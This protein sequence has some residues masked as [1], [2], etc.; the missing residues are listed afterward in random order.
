MCGAASGES[1][2]FCALPIAGIL[3]ELPLPIDVQELLGTVDGLT[4]PCNPVRAPEAVYEWRA[5]RDGSYRFIAH[6]SNPTALWI[7]ADSCGGPTLACSAPALDSGSAVVQLGAG[8]V[9]A[10]ILEPESGL[11][12]G[13]VEL[14]IASAGPAPTTLLPLGA[15]CTIGSTTT[16]CDSGT[17]CSTDPWKPQDQVQAGEQT[18]CVAIPR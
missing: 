2:T 10:A 12:G 16:V 3:G 5:P 1:L 18:L 9:V 11:A 8:R 15:A 4:L 14:S 13:W 6:G 17:T 7:T